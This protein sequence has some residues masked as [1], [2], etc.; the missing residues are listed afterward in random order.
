MVD[1]GDKTEKTGKEEEE[2]KEAEPA[3]P[4]LAPPNAT[5]DL[6]KLLADDDVKQVAELGKASMNSK[7][8]L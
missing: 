2:A 5:Y 1:A 8:E 4:G 3:E 6:D 7:D